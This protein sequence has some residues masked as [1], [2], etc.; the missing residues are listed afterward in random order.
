M[1]AMPN[2]VETN[3]WQSLEQNQNALGNIVI[4]SELPLFHVTSCAALSKFCMKH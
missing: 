1:Q 3:R 2:Q 4:T